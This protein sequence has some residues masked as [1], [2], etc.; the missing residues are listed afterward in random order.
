M[1]R[2]VHACLAITDNLGFLSYEMLMTLSRI[3]ISE[4]KEIHVEP[5]R[6]R[7][8]RDEVEVVLAPG[9]DDL[10]ADRAEVVASPAK[11]SSIPDV[12]SPPAGAGRKQ[13]QSG[14]R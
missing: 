13:P 3:H 11:R 8:G 10:R 6:H 2:L 14:P 12:S 1:K 9:V 4:K 7:P 5:V